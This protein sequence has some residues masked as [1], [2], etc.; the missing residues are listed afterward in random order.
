MHPI[1]IQAAMSVQSTLCKSLATGTSRF[2]LTKRIR[3]GNADRCVQYHTGDY[4]Q[5]RA[6]RLNLA[7]VPETVL[8]DKEMAIPSWWVATSEETRWRGAATGCLL[9]GHV[10]ILDE[11]I[12]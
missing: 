8:S 6:F 1:V 5:L 2:W 9:K 7:P 12:Y 10:R 3:S 4:V 11:L